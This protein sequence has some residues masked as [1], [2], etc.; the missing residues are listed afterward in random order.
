M[1][2]GG[3]LRFATNIVILNLKTRKIKNWLPPVKAI[4][5]SC[6]ILLK[7]L[8]CEHI[9]VIVKAQMRDQVFAH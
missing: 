7:L 9:V 3:G 6:I 2:S 1:P 8:T 5:S 4:T